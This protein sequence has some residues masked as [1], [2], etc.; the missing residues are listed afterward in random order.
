MSVFWIVC[1]LPVVTF[2]QRL[3]VVQTFSEH[4]RS[5]NSFSICCAA[6]VA[7]PVVKETDAIITRKFPPF[8]PKAH[9]RL[10]IILLCHLFRNRLGQICF[11]HWIFFCF[12]LFL[13]H[14]FKVTQRWLFRHPSKWLLA[15]RNIVQHSAVLP[16]CIS[17]KNT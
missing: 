15:T 11:I 12:L 4:S 5:S 17:K 14:K 16:K 8:V 9:R 1:H 2:T 6:K 10:I 13:W 3:Q 7:D